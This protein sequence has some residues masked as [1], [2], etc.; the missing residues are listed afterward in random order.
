MQPNEARCESTIIEVRDILG[1]MLHDY[2]DLHNLRCARQCF[3]ISPMPTPKLLVD[4]RYVDPPVGRPLA[5][6]SG[7]TCAL[8]VSLPHFAGVRGDEFV[9]WS[10]EM[11]LI[12][13]P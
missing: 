2:C 6:L 10:M 12:D 1:P 3:K 7:R 9:R 8:H 4:F 11:L 13:H 5:V